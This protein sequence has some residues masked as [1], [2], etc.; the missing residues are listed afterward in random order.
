MKIKRIL[1][2]LI[3]T[4]CLLFG[5]LFMQSCSSED[6][7]DKTFKVL[8]KADMLVASDEFQEYAIESRSLADR[9]ALNYFNL[10]ESERDRVNILLDDLC[11]E[12]NENN[13]ISYEKYIEFCDLIG[14]DYNEEIKKLNKLKSGVLNHAE[15]EGITKKDIMVSFKKYEINNSIHTLKTGGEYN[16]EDREA[17]RR[18]CIEACKAAYD[19]DVFAC[20]CDIIDGMPVKGCICLYLALRAYK[21]C[22]AAC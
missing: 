5:A 4:V 2:T 7:S 11:E 10:Q 1:T 17:Q 6:E 9:F 16:E 13:S 3:F 8:T 22:I 20:I 14:I 18:K 21:R 19:A 12:A 15:V